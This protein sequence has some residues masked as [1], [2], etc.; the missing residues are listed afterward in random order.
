M[1][2]TLVVISKQ[3]LDHHRI[4]G[5]GSSN[6]NPVY[7][8]K[9]KERLQVLSHYWSLD[10]HTLSAPESITTFLA[11]LSRNKATFIRGAHRAVETCR[12][13]Y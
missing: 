11:E 3:T 1:V 5:R 7:F 13:C 12:I 2:L 4:C 10:P 6:G 9:R 8:N